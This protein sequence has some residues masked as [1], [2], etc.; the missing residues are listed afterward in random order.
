MGLQFHPEVEHS[1]H[2]K[3]ILD[4]FYQKIAKL[5]KDWNANEMLEEAFSMVREVGEK[6]VLCAFSGGVD[7]L[8][9]ATLSQRVLGNNLF[10]FFV[11]NGLL[12]TQDYIHIE[13]LKKE[14]SLNIEIIDAKKDFLEA[15]KNVS[16]PEAKRKIIGKMFIEI[17]EKK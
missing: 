5:T 13:K 11:D 6:K 4:F 1:K 9:A 15:L 8:V 2:G 7:S 10:C 17:F 3:S 12:R 14:T 16:E